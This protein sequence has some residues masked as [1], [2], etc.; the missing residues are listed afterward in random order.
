MIGTQSLG[1]AHVTVTRRT[2][3]S[4]AFASSK[5]ET[6][7]EIEDRIKAT[8][9][10]AQAHCGSLEPTDFILFPCVYFV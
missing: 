3:D 1:G 6:R 10:I 7:V 5:I 2:L 8:A 9:I 4:G